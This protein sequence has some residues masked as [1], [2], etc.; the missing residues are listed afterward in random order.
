MRVKHPRPKQARGG[1][2]V[3]P[4]LGCLSATRPRCQLAR[5]FNP[6]KL[7]RSKRLGSCWPS[8][9]YPGSHVPH[10]SSC[11]RQ[12]HSGKNQAEVRESDSSP[13]AL[14]T[15]IAGWAECSRPSRPVFILVDSGRA[16]W[17]DRRNRSSQPSGA[18]ARAR[19]LDAVSTGVDRAP[20][21]SRHRSDRCRERLVLP[22][23]CRTNRQCRGSCSLRPGFGDKTDHTLPPKWLSGNLSERCECY[24]CVHDGSNTDLHGCS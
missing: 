5:E 4:T 19:A 15:P 22:A 2:I 11:L 10:R 13:R 14:E 12:G 1:G 8:G 6:G 23:Q 9:S 18:T 16:T 17:S 7:S 20:G 21:K 24:T 3:V